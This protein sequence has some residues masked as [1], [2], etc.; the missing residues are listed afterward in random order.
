MT[1]YFNFLNLFDEDNRTHNTTQESPFRVHKFFPPKF[2]HSLREELSIFG[3]IYTASDRIPC[4][5]IFWLLCT[6]VLGV[7]S[8]FPFFLY[9]LAYFRIFVRNKS[10][11]LNF[12][13]SFINPLACQNMELGKLIDPWDYKEGRK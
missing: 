13:C 1:L 3:S 8:C 7:H 9:F 12:N 4:K 11:P 6:L 2:Y 5:F 10:T